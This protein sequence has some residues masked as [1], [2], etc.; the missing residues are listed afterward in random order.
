[1]RN[2]ITSKQFETGEVKLTDEWFEPMYQDFFY[3][4]VPNKRIV[5]F[6]GCETGIILH[7][8]FSDV[9]EPT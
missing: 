7:P 5:G 3:Y 1:M 6:Q 8:E 4:G 9:L 2:M